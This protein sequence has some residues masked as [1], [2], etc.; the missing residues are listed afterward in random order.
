MGS[1]QRETG[2][3][4]PSDADL[5]L[6][7]RRGDEAAWELLVRRY[8]RLVYSIPRRAGLGED[9]AAEVFQQVFVIL[10]ERLERIEQPERIGAW[11]ATTARRETGRVGRAEAAA[12]AA[13]AGAGAGARDDA[14]AP[15]ELPDDAPLADEVLLRLEEQHRVRAAVASLDERC[16]V[17]L[18]LLFYRREPPPYSEVAA[19]LGTPE[20]SIGPTRARCL[21]KLRQVLERLEHTAGMVFLGMASALSHGACL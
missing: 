19:T 16:R 5:V 10:V 13:T 14:A 3:E 21:Q 11:L 8:Q 12:R 4:A 1:G 2:R 9:L 20:G 18:T 17:L 7:C 15:L 6:A